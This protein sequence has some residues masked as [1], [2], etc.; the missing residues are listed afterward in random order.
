[1]SRSRRNY[2]ITG[3]S[4]SEKADKRRVNRRLRRAMNML[5]ADENVVVPVKREISNRYWWPKDGA[6]WVDGRPEALRK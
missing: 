1:M 4:R 6:C 3:L 2:P 5:P